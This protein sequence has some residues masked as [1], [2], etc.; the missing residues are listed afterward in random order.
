V[1]KPDVIVVGA[2]AGGV[3]ALQT[4]AAGL[5]ADLPAA[6][7]VVLHI[8]SGLNGNSLLPEILKHAGAL[9][10]RQVVDREEIRPG[11]I[12]VAAPNCHFVIEPGRLRSVDGPKENMTRPAINPLFRSAAAAYG[13]QIIGVILTGLLDDGVAGLA[14]IKRKGGLAVVQNPDTA[15][16]PSMPKNALRHVNADYVLDLL[17]IPTVLARLVH[18]DRT[19]KEVVEPMIRTL[20]KLTCPECSG[21]LSEEKQGT[22]VEYRCRV[23]HLFSPLALSKEQ[24][25]KL[26]R[27]I[28]ST[29]VALEE[30][31]EIFEMVSDECSAEQAAFRREQVLALKKALKEMN[32]RAESE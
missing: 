18:T 16:Y 29:I 21:P 1:A 3:E 28:W 6:V 25:V 23:G 32:A 15:L 27:T 31:A 2:S 7:C 10:A 22:I 9:P 17:D 24:H 5:P 20:I 26:E 12:Y 30:A 8:G 14:E 19:A 11:H 4:L 13:A